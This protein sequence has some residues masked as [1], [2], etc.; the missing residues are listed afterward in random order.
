[1]I[2]FVRRLAAVA[3]LALALALPANSAKAQSIADIEGKGKIAVGVLTGIP[4]YDTVDASGNTDGFLAD[5]AR[6]VAKA[7]GVELELVPVNNASRAAAL[8][9]GRVDMLIAQMTATPERAK[10]F[11]MT[12]P[13]GAYEMRFVAAK[14]MKLASLDDLKN[15]RV[16]VP[17][18]GTQDIAVSGYGIE[19]LE[20]VRFDDDATAMRLPLKTSHCAAVS[21]ELPTP[22]CAPDTMT[23]KSPFASA[24]GGI[25]R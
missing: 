15:K 24:S 23:S 8:E 12:N 22:F 19:G 5:L 10:L 16:S 3:G 18:G 25:S 6:A 4:P 17:K 20:V 14:E 1:M 9:S 2:G 21:R 13:Y 11:L 7:L